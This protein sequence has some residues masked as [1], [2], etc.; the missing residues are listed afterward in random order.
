MNFLPNNQ[1]AQHRAVV[2]VLCGAVIISFSGV[3]VKLAHV[4]P[5]ISGFYRVFIGALFLSISV[6]AGKFPVWKNFRYF[7]VSVFCGVIFALDLFVWH[8]CVN[9]VGPGL[10]TIL[11]NFQVFFLAVIGIVFLGERINYTLLIAIPLAMLGL[12]LEVG[13]GWEHLSRLYQRGIYLG[14][15][16]AICYTVYILMLRKLQSVENPLSPLV[17]LTIICISAS[18]VL[19]V[20][21]IV[22]GESFI[23]PDHQSL[24]ALLGYGLFS[25]VIGWALIS[26][27]LSNV[28]AS[29]A[30][31]LLLLQ[32]ALSFVWDI[33]FFHRET[34]Y[35]GSVGIILTLAAIYL[36][37]SGK[38]GK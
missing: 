7:A 34:G 20:E 19:G 31:L 16:T 37:T 9:Y 18:L 32:P 6:F 4:T 14:L 3:Y 1:A 11:G 8:R 10:A 26:K 2:M 12:F 24:L 23:I 21:A 36:G 25:Q 33:L 38:P 30:G 27:A 28:K 5:T 17:N 13:I 29:L 35:I 15:A 22:R